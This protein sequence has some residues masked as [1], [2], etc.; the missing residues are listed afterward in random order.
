[1]KIVELEKT[2]YVK[3]KVLWE[4]LNRLHEELS[5]NFKDHFASFTFE[6]RME[7][8]L[9]KEHLIIFAAQDKTN[10]IGYCIASI[11]RNKGEI[12]SIYIDP[13][14]QKQ[15]IGALLIQKALNWLHEKKC[16]EISVSVA[17][18]NESVLDFYKKFGFHKRFVV[19]QRKKTSPHSEARRVI[20]R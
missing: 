15:R 13:S 12:D 17:E 18:G 14:H 5:G 4:K 9:C 8:L 7:S 11:D 20:S 1:M 3:I 6:K 19:L 10:Y 2:E 16:K